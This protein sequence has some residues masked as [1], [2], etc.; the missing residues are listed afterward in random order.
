MQPKTLAM[1]RLARIFDDECLS[2]GRLGYIAYSA[3]QSEACERA[4]ADDF[5]SDE[6]EV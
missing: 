4:A 5:L 1:I 6:I 3:S 2:S